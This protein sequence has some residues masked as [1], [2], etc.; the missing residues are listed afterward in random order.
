M[1]RTEHHL[2][3]LDFE[4][5]AECKQGFGLPPLDGWMMQLGQVSVFYA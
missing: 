1:E 2:K 5:D 3:I 4:L